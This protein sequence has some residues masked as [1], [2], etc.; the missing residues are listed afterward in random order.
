MSSPS[1]SFLITLID[2]SLRRPSSMLY[3]VEGVTPDT[4][5]DFEFLETVAAM[6]DP[7]A[8]DAE[9]LRAVAGICPAVLG[10]RQWRRVKSELRAAN[11]GKLPTEAV[12]GF[13]EEL[14]EALNSK[15]C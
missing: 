7:D 9:K 15:N 12:M 6:S 3:T 5:N 1:H 4:L 13:I 8:D 14:M 11:G 10:R 2:S